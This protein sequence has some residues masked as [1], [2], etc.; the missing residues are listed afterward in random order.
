MQSYQQCTMRA[1]LAI[2]AVLAVAR[3]AMVIQRR[4]AE[5]KKWYMD[6]YALGM[7]LGFPECCVREFSAKTPGFFQP[8]EADR[9]RVEASMI[10]G[11]PSG[12]IPCHRCAERVLAGEVKLE[13]LIDKQRRLL[14]FPQFPKAFCNEKD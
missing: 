11:E 6:N 3:A 4:R 10:H 2:A 13:G 12:F 7:D 1:L 5:A 8:T 14:I 9:R